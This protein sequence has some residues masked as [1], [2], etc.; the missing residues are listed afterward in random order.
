MGSLVILDV[1]GF[2]KIVELLPNTSNRRG[3]IQISIQGSLQKMVGIDR[4]VHKIGATSPKRVSDL[5]RPWH[6]YPHQ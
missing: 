4:V 2:Y 6:M 3:N 1:L 5:E